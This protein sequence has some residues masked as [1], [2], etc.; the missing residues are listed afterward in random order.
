MKIQSLE[1][2]SKNEENAKNSENEIQKKLDNSQS[3]FVESI[4]KKVKV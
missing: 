4:N 3:M 2:I 1:G